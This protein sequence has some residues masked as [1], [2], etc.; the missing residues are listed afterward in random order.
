[1][2]TKQQTSS[3]LLRYVFLHVILKD[4]VVL[5]VTSSYLATCPIRSRQMCAHENTRLSGLDPRKVYFAV[6]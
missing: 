3:A 1:M 6:T 4:I 5:F 2:Y